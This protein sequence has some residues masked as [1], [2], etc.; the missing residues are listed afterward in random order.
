MKLSPEGKKWDVVVL[1]GIS[2]DFVIRGEA[3]PQQG[4]SVIGDSFYTGPG[5]KGANQAVAAARLGA[6]VALIGMTG[7]DARG[8]ELIRMLR[9]NG[10]DVGHVGLDKDSP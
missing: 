4:Q 8:R 7:D 5:G 2:T 10:V 1:G 3:L 6:K 9:R